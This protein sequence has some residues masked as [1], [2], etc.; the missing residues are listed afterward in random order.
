[1]PNHEVPIDEPFVGR[2][3]P[4]P[5]VGGIPPVLPE[6]LAA[7]MVATAFRHSPSGVVCECHLLRHVAGQL[8]A[9]GML[10]TR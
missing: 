4:D 9:G 5:V 6:V 3:L 10:R 7:A 2:D 8:L 1:M